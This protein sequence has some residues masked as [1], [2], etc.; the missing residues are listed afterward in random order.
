MGRAARILAIIDDM[1]AQQYPAKTLA[2]I[3]RAVD[4]QPLVTPE[5]LQQLYR[6]EVNAVRGQDL[7]RRMKLELE[8]AFFSTFYKAFLIGH[9][10]VGKST[11]MSR[12]ILQLESKYVPVR[13]SAKQDLDPGNL[14]PFD[15]V[16]VMVMQLIE[17]ARK[18]E[19][20]G[21][22]AFAPPD[23]VLRPLLDWLADKT[24]RSDL[25]REM[26]AEANAGAG[27]ESSFL[28]KA[29]GIFAG[30]KGEIRYA[31]S[32][33]KEQVEHQL[34][35]LSD[36]L[37]IANNILA[38]YRAA[39]DKHSHREWLFIGEDFDKSGS[40]VDVT[41][42]LFLTYGN[43]FR[44][45]ECHLIF[46]IPI[47]LVYSQAGSQL[48]FNN[49]RILCIP[50]TPVFGKDHQPHEEGRAAVRAVL[51]A[52]VDPALFG[53]DQM[54][55]LI[56][57][58]GGNLRDLFSMVNHASLNARLR[59]SDVME[60]ADVAAAVNEM[61]I[62]YQRRL[63]VSPYDPE[64]VTFEKKVERLEAIYFRDPDADVPDPV[65][66]SL[67]N[68]RAVQEFNGERWFGVHPLVVELLR[69]RPG[70]LAM[71]ESEPKPRT[72]KAK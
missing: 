70:R 45:L 65:L 10:G 3:S 15:V 22:I 64:E 27:G 48:P 2:A 43:L 60:A 68:A 46:S 16:L 50:D 8:D 63:G 13:L 23:H 17:Q 66:H 67:L 47:A 55:K 51:S 71:V 58:S 72:K 28:A 62:T 19:D 36:L 56:V 49:N 31:A 18:P 59:E 21:G 53:P 33:R 40:A 1:S 38:I 12:L 35:R 34:R 25:G 39:L 52:R 54:E 29:I 11:E 69:R 41:E 32:R 57:D 37:R 61:R 4:P 9:S 26:A 44:E 5:Q 20:E 24:E 14:E 7:V 30:V 42:K 6:P